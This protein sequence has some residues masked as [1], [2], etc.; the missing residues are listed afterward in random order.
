MVLVLEI[1]LP[2][3]FGLRSDVVVDV[4]FARPV[5]VGEKSRSLRVLWGRPLAVIAPRPDA[6]GR[7]NFH[8]V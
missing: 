1:C 3:V 8:V 5:T 4:A 6:L 7:L 2:G